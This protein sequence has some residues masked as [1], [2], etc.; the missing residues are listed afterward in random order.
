MKVYAVCELC[1][2]SFYGYLAPDRIF[3][4]KEK[5]NAHAK[6]IYDDGQYVTVKEYELE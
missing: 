6:E 3:R 1:D 5:A 2:D 4:D